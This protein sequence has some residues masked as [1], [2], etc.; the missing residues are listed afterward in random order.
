M[1]LSIGDMDYSRHRQMRAATA[2]DLCIGIVII[3]IYLIQISLVMEIH[4][5]AF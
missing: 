1:R 2:C 3:D 4:M 5:T